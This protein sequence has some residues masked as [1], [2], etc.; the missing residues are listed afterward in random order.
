MF[1]VRWMIS[2]MTVILEP[3]ARGMAQS[4]SLSVSQARAPSQPYGP[5]VQIDDILTQK[6]PYVPPG[7]VIPP[8]PNPHRLRAAKWFLL[9]RMYFTHP[10]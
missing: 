4:L 2:E 1:P 10:F 6:A 3:N 8:R 5:A 7:D 9:A